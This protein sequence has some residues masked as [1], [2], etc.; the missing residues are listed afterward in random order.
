MATVCCCSALI[1][2]IALPLVDR[3]SHSH[4]L[5]SAMFIVWR[6]DRYLSKIWAIIIVI[7]VITVPHPRLH[8]SSYS[9][10]IVTPMP[11]FLCPCCTFGSLFPKCHLTKAPFFRVQSLFLLLCRFRFLLCLFFFLFSACIFYVFSIWNA[12]FV[13]MPMHQ[14]VSL[15]ISSSGLHKEFR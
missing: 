11:L 2:C 15:H 12:F 3:Y 4:L 9:D 1:S 8:F 6:I 5:R 14:I 7:V 10:C 13:C